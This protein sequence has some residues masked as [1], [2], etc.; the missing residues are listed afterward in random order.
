MMKFIL[1]SGSLL[2]QLRIAN[3]VINSNGLIPILETFLFEIENN[4]LSIS[5]TDTQTNLIT[6]LEVSESSNGK[7]A[8]PAKIILETLK[9]LPDQPL[10]FLIDE[11]REIIIS[12][13][14]GNY[15]IAGYL[16]DDFPKINKI[17]G[18]SY[19]EVPANILQKA[20]QKTSTVATEDSKS[21]ILSGI[22]MR[23]DEQGTTFFGTDAQRIVRYSRE[24][25]KNAEAINLIIPKKPVALLKHLLVGKNM[26]VTIG[27]EEKNL[28][29]EID[30]I[31]L[32]CR[33]VEGKYPDC[34]HIIPQNY[35][36]EMILDRN[37]LLQSVQRVA[38]FSSKDSHQI[39]FKTAP[40]S[41]L[42]YSE[43]KH[44]SHEAKENIQCNYQG[45]PLEISFSA[46]HLLEAI[47][48]IDTAEIQILFGLPTR[49]ALL[50]PIQNDQ[51]EEQINLI[52]PLYASDNAENDK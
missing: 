33:L 42:I 47:K 16:G 34:N 14:Y 37:L 25:I 19:V 17:E 5:A 40:T 9:N 51:Y 2:K 43:D 50:S 22:N 20:I 45:D 49:P 38:I 15:K 44:N 1:S 27:Y 41:L 46:R 7:V 8:I 6:Y 11:N 39:C 31:E 13:T 30:G 21:A 3:E 29:F 18:L 26:P 36:N 35:P 4:I 48:N 12:S 24:D 28:V 23:I 10:S 32:S 52:T